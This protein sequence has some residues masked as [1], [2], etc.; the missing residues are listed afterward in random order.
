MSD[1]ARQ[2]ELSAPLLGEGNSEPAGLASGTVLAGRYRVERLLGSGGM[3]AV[4]LAEHILMKKAVAVKVLHREMTMHTEVVARFE[5][6]AVAAARI[7]HPNVAAAMDFGRLGD[8]SFYLALEYVG[9]NSLRTL[10][11]QGALPVDRVLAIATQI[12]HALVAAH[13]AGIVHRDL[14][15]DNVMLIPQTGGGDLVK[16]LDFGIAKVSNTDEPQESG[17]ILTR[18]G[19]VMGTAG[20][21]APEQ[22]LGTAVD[23]RADLYSFG[24]VAY[25]AL[26]GHL[27]FQAEEAAQILAKQLTESP[28]PLPADV[29]PDLA[30]LL[31]KLL[32]RSPDERLQSAAELVLELDRIAA[33][34]RS[35]AELVVAKTEVMPSQPMLVAT[36][37]S[38]ITAEPIIV[39]KK[40]LP[41]GALVGIGLVAAALLATAATLYERRSA[42]VSAV[43]SAVAS[44]PSNLVSAPK[45][46][47]SV[48]PVVVPPASAALLP[49]AAVP[50]ATSTTETRTTTANGTTTTTRTTRRTTVEQHSSHSR[51]K[52]SH[53]GLYIPP[54]SQWFK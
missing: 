17:R 41:L 26:S 51:Q 3:G 36:A 7:D 15:P 31:V 40:G 44:A 20:Y 9:G 4:Y 39:P 52:R 45:A 13:A 10:I 53:G 34:P 35:R 19:T 37:A 46:L 28:E 5:R 8:G 11:D 27:P 50:R 18:Y 38:A 2:E 30:A 6:E 22:A 54:P 12:A 14:K 21:M 33:L 49:S 47:P 23:A 32:A 24:V 1:E 42:E 25:E 48:A 43:P 29:P 16:V